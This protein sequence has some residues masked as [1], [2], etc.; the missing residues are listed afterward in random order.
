MLN[1]RC[2]KKLFGVL[3]IAMIFLTGCA[4]GSSEWR[5][6]GVCASVVEYSREE[7]R[8]VAEEVEALP[9]DSVIVGW[10]ADYAVLRAQT[11]DCINSS[12]SQK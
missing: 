1:V 5:G 10:L 11:R 9:E 7:Q 2:S 8:R 3:A 4:T 6:T 12:I